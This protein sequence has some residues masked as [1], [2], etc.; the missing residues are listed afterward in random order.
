MKW[1]CVAVLTAPPERV[2]RIL[3]ELDKI[4]AWER[5][6]R[7]LTM[8]TPGPMQLGS[9]FREVRVS[10]GRRYEFLHQVTRYD[11]DRT[12]CIESVSGTM[13]FSGC[14]LLE[15]VEGGTRVIETGE[16][17]MG[18][19]WELFA[20]LLGRI[21]MRAYAESYEKIRRMLEAEQ[22]AS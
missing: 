12:F 15:P 6:I 19:I 16:L 9:R 4:S 8:V 18:G 2:F 3:T 10:A 22:E 21:V 1:T 7:E 11:R 14:R 5:D 17:R 20:P 13:P